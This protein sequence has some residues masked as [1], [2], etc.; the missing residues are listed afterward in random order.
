MACFYSFIAGTKYMVMRK[1]ITIAAIILISCFGYNANAQVAVQFN[2]G[3]Q[4]LWGPTGYT[5][6]QYYYIPDIGAYYD[7]ANQDYVYSQNGQWVTTAY[8]PPAY[9]NFDLYNAYKVVINSPSP[10]L[11]DDMYRNRYYSFRGHTG[12]PVIRDSHDQRYWANPSHPMHNHWNGAERQGSWG[13]N[14]PRE[15]HR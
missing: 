6:A 12:Q 13:G 9:A 7:V 4:P 15:D 11:H 5:Y 14:R 3:V 2:V 10:W 1:R 8:L